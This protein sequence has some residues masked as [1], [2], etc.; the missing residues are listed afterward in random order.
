MMTNPAVIVIAV[1]HAAP[2]AVVAL[3]LAAREETVVAAA[4]DSVR[5]DL[6]RSAIRGR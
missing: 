4:A 1:V 2:R 6:R 3:A 5:G